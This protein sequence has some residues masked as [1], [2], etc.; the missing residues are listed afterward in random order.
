MHYK[1]GTPATLG[2][3]IQHDS[4]FVGVVIGGTIGSDFCSTHVVKL[5]PVRNAA[6]PKQTWGMAGGPGFVGTLRENTGELKAVAAVAV[7]LDQSVQTRECLKIGH[8]DIGHG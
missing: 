5:S 8:I 7:S 1:D 3:I 6:D 2:D 4:G